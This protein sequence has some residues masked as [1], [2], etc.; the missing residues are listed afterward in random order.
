M[1]IYCAFMLST[2]LTV[3]LTYV[4][5]QEHLRGEG[6]TDTFMKY[7]SGEGDS[8]SGF[9]LGDFYAGEGMYD[10]SKESP[11]FAQP[12]VS[13]NT[14][15]VAATKPEMPKATDSTEIANV[16]RSTPS[17]PTNSSEGEIMVDKKRFN[18]L[19]EKMRQNSD[20]LVQ[21][22]R[23]NAAFVVKDFIKVTEEL[24]QQ[25]RAK[26]NQLASTIHSASDEL[27][28]DNAKLALAIENAYKQDSASKKSN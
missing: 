3:D 22:L 23:A 10:E 9:L 8:F 21:I 12:T 11:L 2:I 15:S 4:M 20:E 5:A 13:N 27:A 24:E 17:T 6:I 28:A 1:R 7:E 19:A 26:S 16:I 25:I 18:Q 14:E